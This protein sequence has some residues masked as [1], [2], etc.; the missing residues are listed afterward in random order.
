[1]VKLLTPVHTPLLQKSVAGLSSICIA[2][3]APYHSSLG[4]CHVPLDTE[5]SAIPDVPKFMKPHQHTVIV[6]FN[7]HT[8]PMYFYNSNF[9]NISVLCCIHHLFTVNFHVS[10]G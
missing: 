5:L 1:M 7:I 10:T 9:S 2:K 6:V 8:P 3:F 4:R